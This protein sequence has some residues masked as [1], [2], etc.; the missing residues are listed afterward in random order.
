MSRI[1]RNEFERI[2][3][4]ERDENLTHAELETLLTDAKGGSLEARQRIVTNFVP[5]VIN[6]VARH[7]SDYTY[8]RRVVSAD[9]LIQVGTIAVFKAIDNWKPGWLPFPYLVKC[10]IHR[11][12]RYE[13][14]QIGGAVRLPMDS[15][16]VW[17]KWVKVRDQLTDEF[18]RVPSRD[19]IMA[20]GEFTERDAFLAELLDRRRSK[21]RSKPSRFR[22]AGMSRSSEAVEPRN[23]QE[24]ADLRID[25]AEGMSRL[26]APEAETIRARF[27]IDGRTPLKLREVAE[28]EGINLSAAFTREKRALE[29]L[30]YL[31]A[32]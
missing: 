2:G 17:R 32:V 29:K 25:V 9:D 1:N 31:V 5:T 8:A 7:Y 20:R 19:E 4:V 11:E 23:D 26:P 24:K 10:W 6:I 18:L 30:A 28:Q 14:I 13:L 22:R 12:I 27:G 16:G 15:Y 3:R 21:I